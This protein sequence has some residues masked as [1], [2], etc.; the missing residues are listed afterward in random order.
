MVK[1]PIAKGAYVRLQV[2][3]GLIRLIQITADLCD[4]FRTVDV[5][6]PVEPGE[7]KLTHDVQLPTEIPP[8]RMRW[9]AGREANSAADMADDGLVGVWKIGNVHR[10]RRCLLRRR[11][12]Y[13]LFD[14][15]DHL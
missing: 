15:S 5:K 12:T 8:V 7:A 10:R 2:K 6:C 13:R 14:H 3:W 9:R 11:P 1:K 4:Q